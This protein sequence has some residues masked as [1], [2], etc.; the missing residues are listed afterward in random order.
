V[1]VNKLIAFNKIPLSHKNIW[2][3]ELVEI[4]VEASCHPYPNLYDEIKKYCESKEA[5]L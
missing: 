1:I 3:D 4:L 5:Q 2:K